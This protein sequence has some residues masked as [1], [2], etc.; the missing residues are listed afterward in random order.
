MMEALYEEV[1]RTMSITGCRSV[2][3]IDPTI[4]HRV[5]LVG[6]AVP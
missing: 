2:D 3:G 5:D 4:L 1:G 6:N